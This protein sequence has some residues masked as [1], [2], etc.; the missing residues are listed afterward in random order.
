M[1][2]PEDPTSRR[3]LLMGI[4]PGTHALG[5]GVIEADGPR[6]RLVA[7]DTIRPPRLAETPAERLGAIADAL[8]R[9]IAE[10]FA[11]GECRSINVPNGERVT[12]AALAVKYH[13]FAKSYYIKDGQPT[14]ERY[15]IKAAIAPLVELYGATADDDFGPKRLKAV[16]EYI[17]SQGRRRDG[18][19]LTRKYVNRRIACIVRMF[20]WAVFLR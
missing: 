12:V 15:A 18:Q 16:R 14:D 19:P 8:A 6:M 10:H 3:A 1:Q 20:R 9:V 11:N 7:S 2:G 4:D 17:V 13:D 5:W